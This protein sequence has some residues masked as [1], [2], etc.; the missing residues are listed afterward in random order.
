VDATCVNL[1][2]DTYEWT[3][4]QSDVWQRADFPSGPAT[5]VHTWTVCGVSQDVKFK[6][7]VHRGSFNDTSVKDFFVTG[8]SLKA[9]SAGASYTF[10]SHLAVPPFDGSA[11]GRILSQGSA[12]L[13]DS[14]QPVV[15]SARA[16]GGKNVIEA[17]LA[18]G[19]AEGGHWRFGFSNEPRFVRGSLRVLQGNVVSLEPAGAVFALGV[20]A[21]DRIRF[22]IELAP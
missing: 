7:M 8:S 14:S 9:P 10:H 20:Q 3:L 17:V 5:F 22:E 16:G 1:P 2:V 6:L 18:R 13:V 4:D 15:I 11:R 19:D 21:P 12:W